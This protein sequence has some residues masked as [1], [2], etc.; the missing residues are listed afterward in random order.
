MLISIWNLLSIF[1]QYW[2]IYFHIRLHVQFDENTSALSSG[3]SRCMDIHYDREDL[4]SESRH[5][6]S[7]IDY[8]DT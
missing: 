3:Q 6:R 7:M 8:L 5:E 1:C 4:H 2:N